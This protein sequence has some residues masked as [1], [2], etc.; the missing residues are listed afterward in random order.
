[1]APMIPTMAGT[2]LLTGLYD[3]KAAYVNVIGVFTNTVPI[4]A[5]RGAGRPEASHIV[6]R[7]VDKAALDL[8]LD[9]AEIRRRNFIKKEQMPYKAPLGPNYDSGHFVKNMEDALRLADWAGAAGR[10]A[11]AS[12]RGKLRGIGLGC[13]VEAAAGAP[14]EDVELIF[15]KDGSV[16]LLIGTLTN[17]QG[18]ATSYSQ[19]LE[20]LLGLPFDRIKVLQGDT[21]VVKTGGGTGGSKSMML[22]A[23]AIKSA[24]DKVIE[25]GK[26]IAAHMLEAAEADIEFAEGVFRIVGTDRRMTIGE[27]AVAART[28]ANLPKGLEPGLDTKGQSTVDSGTYPNG[29]HVCEVEVDRDTGVVQVVNYTV[30]DDF[31]K[32]INPLLVEGQVHGGIVQGIGQ[33][34]M[35]HAI[36]DNESGQ[37]LTGSFM[38]YTMPRAD[39]VPSFKLAFNEVLCTTNPLGIKGAGEAGTVGALGAVTNAIVDALRPLGVS[40]IEM[41]ATP[42]R[43]WQVIQQAKA[44]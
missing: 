14:N 23:A 17:G 31:G 34:M 5:Y 11:S 39:N 6:E 43:V 36:Y 44:A 30:V 38:D 24:S 15:E 32:I 26:K 3:I 22:G 8:N 37:L 4:D 13:Y 1:F 40:H 27:I 18:H 20:E 16:T 25:K 29:C 9:P 10:K 33:A 42:E 7:L 2:G 35:E 19:V 41:P 12:K 21:D 28:T